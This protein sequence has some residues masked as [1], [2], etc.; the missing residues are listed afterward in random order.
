MEEEK[1]KNKKESALITP[2]LGKILFL[3]FF[4]T[5]LDILIVEL[6]YRPLEAWSGIWRYHVVYIALQYG[7]PLLW[8]IKTRSWYPLQTWILWLFGLE[9]T[10]FYLLQ[11]RIPERFWGVS[12][13]GVWQPGWDWVFT[14]NTIGL[15]LLL[16]LNL[17][18]LREWRKSERRYEKKINKD[19]Q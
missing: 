3:F 18:F 8:A 14:I 4:L 5:L 19:F 7:I 15:T 1:L 12:I 9:D 2:S 6:Y 13:A 17:E 11:G 10:A 16:L